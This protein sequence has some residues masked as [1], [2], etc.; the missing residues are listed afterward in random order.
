MGLL[1]TKKISALPSATTPLT[2]DEQL[3]CVQLGNSRKIQT[4][5]LVLPSDSL[6][7]VSGMGGALPGSRSLSSGPGITF[8]DGGPGGTLQISTTGVLP[9]P[10]TGSFVGELHGFTE[11]T[12]ITLNYVIIENM[13]V[14]TNARGEV[15]GVSNTTSMSLTGLPTEI[16]PT[17]PGASPAG[18]ALVINAAIPAPAFCLVN[19]LGEIHFWIQ[20]S[21]TAGSPP[22]FSSTGFTAVGLKGLMAGW[23]FMYPIF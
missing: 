10:V 16:L 1:P 17:F 13:V 3:E 22:T 7:T 23:S 12:P 15:S 2:G 20:R 6:V 4:R 11:F 21:T 5:D 9:P 19:S 18:P 8:T 14:V